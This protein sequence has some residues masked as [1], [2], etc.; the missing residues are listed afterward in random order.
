MITCMSHTSVYVLDQEAAKAFYT[1]TL[2]FELTQDAVFDGF[3]WITVRP[4]DQ[5]ELE[6]VLMPIMAYGPIDAATAEATRS[7]VAGGAFLCGVQKTDDCRATVETLR[8]KGVAIVMEP[9]S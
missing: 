6:I 7:L 2:G 5:K 3:R 1:E 4:G 8:A 9:R